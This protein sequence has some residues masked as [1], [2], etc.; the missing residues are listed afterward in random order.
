MVERWAPGPDELAHLKRVAAEE[1]YEALIAAEG[2]LIE[3]LGDSKWHPIG[4]CPVLRQVQRALAIARGEA[5]SAGCIRPPNPE[6]AA[7]YWVTRRRADATPGFGADLRD[8]RERLRWDGEAWISGRRW[9]DSNGRLLPNRRRL[10][11]SNG[12][13]I[14]GP[15]EAPAPG[16][17]WPPPAASS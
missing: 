10:H 2:H 3:T 1:M 4:D 14:E 11:S 9:R 15:A 5:S 12:W 7:D 13:R 17:T 16:S 8:V 6:V